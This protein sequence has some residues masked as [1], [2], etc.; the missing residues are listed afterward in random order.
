[1]RKFFKKIKASVVKVREFVM[2]KLRKSTTKPIDENPISD[3]IKDLIADGSLEFDNIQTSIT[4]QQ[5][6]TIFD[7]M[8]GGFSPNFGL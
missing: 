1:M 2:R 4:P 3:I 5:F 6:I 7:A 8:T